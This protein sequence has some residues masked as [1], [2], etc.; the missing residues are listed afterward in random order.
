[1][2]RQATDWEEIVA[3]DTSTEGLLS[4]IHKEPKTQQEVGIIKMY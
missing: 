1:M 3:K 4:Q 2:K